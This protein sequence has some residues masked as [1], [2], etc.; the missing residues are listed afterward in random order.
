MLAGIL[1]RPA[2]IYINPDS[3]F[4]S[5]PYLASLTSPFCGGEKRQDCPCLVERGWD[6]MELCLSFRVPTMAESRE[7]LGSSVGL[8]THLTVCTVPSPC[9]CN[10]SFWK[11]P[12]CKDNVSDLQGETARA[13]IGSPWR[14]V[15]GVYESCV[16]SNETVGFKNKYC[17]D[18]SKK[19]T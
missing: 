14:C 13:T 18:F 6:G 9:S 19:S 16:L 8:S 15:Y 11:G 12:A 3:V 4:K 7:E 10:P 5:F 17:V 1:K 2:N